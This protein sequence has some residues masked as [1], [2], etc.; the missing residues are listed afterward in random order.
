[1]NPVIRS[2]PDEEEVER[3]TNS[4]VIDTSFRLVKVVSYLVIFVAGAILGLTASSHVNRYIT[5]QTDLFYAR[6]S[7]PAFSP[8]EFCLNCSIESASKPDTLT[9]TM[10][11]E[12][13]F[14][15][16]SMVPQKGGY[17]YKR[18]PKVAFMFLTRGP[19]PLSPLWE[20][21]FQGHEELFSI[22][23]HTV[24]GYKLNVSETSV[25]YG[26][27]IPSK[28]VQWGGITLADAER[29][30]LANALLDFANERFVLL[31]ESCIPVYD[32]GTV[33]KYLVDSA[34]SFVDSYDDPS[35]Y[36][37]GRYSRNMYPEIKLHQWRKGSQWFEMNRFLAVYIISDT[38]YYSIFSK[39]C[40][41]SCYPDEHY[42]P[43]Y[44]NMFFQTANS[45][46]S[47]TWVDWSRGGPHP[48]TY[49]GSDITEGFIQSIRNNGTIC[50]YNSEKTSLCYL[51]ARKFAPS[52]LE[53]LLNLTSTVTRF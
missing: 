14:W 24:P 23:I 25:F 40:H 15:R 27:Q 17:P 30:L 13:L 37:R 5:A 38:K 36:G 51:F 2:R 35:R 32:F 47:V 4:I 41:P 1:M 29:R 7:A 33:Y 50:L 18:T 11:D 31:S 52:A 48:A 42:V 39:H 26:R 3:M 43:T 21:F 49:G 6:G 34:H 45:N 19:L 46:R 12:E 22:Y 44:L 16:A 9:H 10:T 8:K 53:P 20:R 28:D